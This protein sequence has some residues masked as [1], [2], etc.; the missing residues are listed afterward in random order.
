MTISDERPK[1]G[2]WNDP[3]LP[4]PVRAQA[5]LAAMTPAEKI[6]Q[7]G[8]TWP[9]HE[10][11]GDV[12][13]MQETFRGAEPFAEAITDGLGQLTRI[14]GTVP[15]TAE[16]GVARLA[17]LQSHVV[18]ANRFG[19]PALAHEEC[20]TGFTTWQATVY[21]TSLAWAATWNPALVREMAA[22]IGADMAAVGIHQGLAPVLD[23]V[24]D[25]RWGRVEETMG[26]DPHLISELGLAYVQ[27]LQSAGV[28][29]TLK[30]FAG[31]SAS[32]GARNHAPAAIGPRELADVILPPFERAVVHGPVR[33][34]MNAYND[35]DGTP[36]AADATLLTGLLRDAWGFTGTVVSDYWSIAF[37]DSMHHV[38]SDLPDAARQALQAGIDVELPHTS[39]YGAALGL[40]AEDGRISP[41]VL[42]RAVLR[43]LT[44]KAEMGLLDEGWSADRY[45][46]V[47]LNSDR[48]R[49]VARRMAEQSVVLLDNHAG[50]LPLRAPRSIAVI[51]PAADD[52]GCL[53]GCYS[54]PNHVLAHHPDLPLGIDAPTVLAA[55]R[56][57]FPDAEV[58]YTPGCSI[59]GTDRSGI[60]AAVEAADAADVT[61][62]VVGDRSGMFGNGTS[63]EG[64]DVATL[65]LPGVQEELTE[66][67]LAA[68]HR[69][70]LLVV[71]G[72]P[73]AIGRHV[74]A[75]EA[76]V[77]AFFPGQEGGTAIAGILAGR[78]NPSGRLPV[79]IPGENSG[80]PGT[81]LAPPLALKSDGVS[82]IDPTPAFP[83]GHGLSYS[84]FRVDEVR[85]GADEIP[86]DGTVVLRATVSNVGDRAG[87]AVPQ[88]YLTDP[89]ASVTRPVRQLIGFAR[90]DLQAGETRTLQ[91]TVSADLAG[92]TGRD[93]RR[94]VEPGRLLLTVAQSAAEA[95]TVAAIRLTGETRYLDHRRTMAAEAQLLD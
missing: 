66:A 28:I 87:T 43:V 40:M 34:V 91:F 46:A 56:A 23:V 50:L 21:P 55:I 32:R 19:I 52:P 62:L 92:F 79:Q 45:R 89:V 90:V 36:C 54:F 13:P 35:V 38:A 73:Y 44:Q 80:Q 57:E 24:R 94:R 59:S 85:A 7:L 26:E 47:D 41:Q 63:G 9:G 42:D 76:T 75:A 61:V 71:S 48:N 88:L 67:V 2:L 70:V 16:E 69:S 77:Q 39:G 83:F 8:S 58:R 64:C 74:D 30:H 6:S 65:H 12:A 18:A 51:G 22:A 31:Y 5:L 37:L 53:F 72:R 93:L 17:A 68:A 95:G 84:V 1:T 81:Y 49:A 25:Y 11:S 27:G 3:G 20:L 14:F 10:G 15:I 60:Q 78:V 82:N 4:A 86:T 33:S 29:A